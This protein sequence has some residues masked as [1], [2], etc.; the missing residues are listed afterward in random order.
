MSQETE[1]YINNNSVN[2]N[3]NNNNTAN[4]THLINNN[5][6]ID[7]MLII[8]LPGLTA[9]VMY[10]AHASQIETRVSSNYL[11]PREAPAPLPKNKDN[12]K[13]TSFALKPEELRFSAN[14]TEQ[15]YRK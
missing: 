11:P 13:Y 15:K 14:Q 4:T 2:N 9:M 3:N 7:A 6:F 12:I 5:K 10:G 1:K 8:A